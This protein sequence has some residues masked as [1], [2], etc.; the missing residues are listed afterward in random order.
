MHGGT[1]NV[2]GD[3]TPTRSYLYA[4]DMTVWLWSL[5]FKATTAHAYNVG[6]AAEVS[7]QELAKAVCTALGT[8]AA[9][10]VQKQAEPN[11]PISRYLPSITKAGDGLGLHVR[12]SLVHGIQ[13]TAAWHG[14]IN[15]SELGCN[16]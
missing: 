12:V 10:S 5:L 6:S 8:K 11:S 4:S 9:V 16:N 13:K 7:I 14:W 1:I 15:P 3:G 2:A